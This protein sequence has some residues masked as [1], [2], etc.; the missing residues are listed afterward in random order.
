MHSL[1]STKS[2]EH[3]PCV[4]SVTRAQKKIKHDRG[5]KMEPKVKVRRIFSL[6]RN[7]VTVKR[8]TKRRNTVAASAGSSVAPVAPVPVPRDQHITRP[9]PQLLPLKTVLKM[10]SRA[11]INIHRRKSMTAATTVPDDG[12]SS[13]LSSPKNLTKTAQMIMNVVNLPKEQLALLQSSRV[14]TS[15][16]S[17]ANMVNGSDANLTLNQ[18][19]R[20]LIPIPGPSGASMVNVDYFSFSPSFGR[21]HYDSDSD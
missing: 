10:P 17:I 6:D 12:L 18:P 20:E 3:F 11:P 5:F 15:N 7:L 8:I 1:K 2:F 16:Q 21:L 4:F 14:G 9:I 19:S 13:N